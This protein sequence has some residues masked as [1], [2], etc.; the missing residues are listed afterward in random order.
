LI[1]EFEAMTLLLARG[2]KKSRS[3]PWTWC[4]S[5]LA[6]ALSDFGPEGISASHSGQTDLG[7]IA[8]FGHGLKG[9]VPGTLDG[10]F[11]VLLEQGRSNKTDNG[12]VVC[13]DAGHVGAS[14]DFAVETLNGMV[15]CS[16]ARCS[17]G[18]VM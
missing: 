8:H 12:L 15:E 5:R 14:F 9:H 11:I 16:F 3:C 4:R 7:I 2:D 1:D 17:P 6:A 13:K 18:K 10:P